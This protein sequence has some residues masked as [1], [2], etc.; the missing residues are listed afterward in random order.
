M[1]FNGSGLFNRI[2]NF[3]TDKTNSVPVTASRMDGELDG[4]ATGLSNCITRDGQSLPSA[5]IP[6]NGQDL[7]GAGTI[8]AVKFSATSQPCFSAHKNGTDQTGIASGVNTKLTFTTEVF[9]IGSFYDAANSKWTPP[10]G[11]VQITAA[12]SVSNQTVN[13]VGQIIIFKNGVAYKKAVISTGATNDGVFVS[14]IDR[15]NGTDF[16]EIYLNAFSSTTITSTGF[17]TTT[18][19]MGFVL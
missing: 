11:M 8:S 4:M 10:A 3:V 6:W 5:A 14:I 12:T 7:T 13:T 17:A 9:D 16:Y 19:F 18:Y 1:A 2:Y 15:A